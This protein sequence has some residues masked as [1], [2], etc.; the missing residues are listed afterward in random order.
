MSEP[1]KSFDSDIADERRRKS[2]IVDLTLD[3]LD[4]T[5]YEFEEALLQTGFGKFHFCLLAVC[6]AIYL[7]TAIGKHMARKC[8]FN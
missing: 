1:V 5:Q 3:F 6:G 4:T 2:S 7:N 8:F